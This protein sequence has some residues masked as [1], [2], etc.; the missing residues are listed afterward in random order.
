MIIDTDMGSDCDDVAALAIAG[1]L[2]R[3]NQA[4][5]LC[6]THTA[7]NP[8]LFE[9]MDS[10]L[11]FYGKQNFELGVSA[12]E[13]AVR[14]VEDDYIEKAVN[15]FPFRKGV[16]PKESVRLLREKLAENNDVTLICI[17]PLNNIAGLMRS[18][19]DDLSPLNGR[20]LI[21]RSVREMI[22]MGGIFEDKVYWFGKEKYDVEFNIRS[23]VKG[24][25]EV[26]G[27]SPVPITFVEFELGYEVESF[28][29]TT[30]SARLTPIKR[31]Y[32]LFG[33]TK[34]SS[35]DPIAVLTA[36]YGLCDGLYKYSPNGT[37]TVDET[38]RFS[39]KTDGGLHR[40]LIENADK[41]ALT[42]YV[43]SFQDKIME[44][45]E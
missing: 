18:Q 11:Q 44:N 3:T 9:Y 8:R 45:I 22:V 41:R 13:N 36:K 16:A 43:D 30:C 23:D 21:A 39:F 25:Q 40:Y 7:S 24:A 27:N 32:E 4:E 37:V 35:W 29:K 10:V 31:T 6:V 26:I 2:H 28:E 19:A 12:S 1:W 14:G 17:G 34:R 15:G 20:E 33:L 42:A 5:L 38:G